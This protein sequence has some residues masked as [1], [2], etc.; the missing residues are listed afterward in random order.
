MIVVFGSIN[1]DLVVR[2]ATLPR[3][4]ETVLAPGYRAVAGGKGANQAVA[5]ARAGAATHM[6]GRVGR[7]AFAEVALATLRQAGVDL[8]GVDAGEAPTGCAMICVDA[9]GN[10]QIAVAS[11]ANREV[12]AAQLDDALLGPGTTLVLQL[13]VDPDETWAVVRRARA[14]GSRIV[15]NIAPAAPVPSEIARSCDVHIM[16]EIEATMLAQQAGLTETDPATAAHGIAGAWGV[17]AVVTLGDAGARAFDGKV[18]WRIGALPVTPVDTTAAGDA[19]VGVFAA[20]LDHGEDL[21]TALRRASVAGALACTKQGA[22]PSL[23]DAAAIDAA[24]PDLAPAE[25][26]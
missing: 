20:T 14:R 1:V 3:P 23:P 25:V 8:A 19:F 16:N 10:N 22:Q 2:V 26:I 7:D 18:A 5:A 21:P 4:G 24:L 15:L 9:Q 6:I 12:R 11:G 17:T 13:E